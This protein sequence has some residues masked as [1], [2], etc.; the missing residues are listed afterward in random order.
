MELIILGTTMYSATTR[1]IL[2]KEGV[3]VLG[4]STYRDYI[5]E[6][7]YDGLPVYPFEELDFIFGVGEFMVINTIGYSNMNKIREKVYYDT[8]KKGYKLYTFISKSALVY[9][10]DIGEGSL[11]M[12]NAYIGPYVKL[13]A[14]CVVNP[15]T[16]LSHHITMGNFNFI[17]RGVIVGGDVEI[18]NNC[19]IG[20]HSTIKNK[21]RI[22]NFT[23][24][25]SGSNVIK[26]TEENCVYV[27]NPA[28][29]VE[30][31]G[32]LSTKI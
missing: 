18:C 13:G 25:G 10:D 29:K 12:P 15:G 3:R 22:S 23:I 4:Y 9:T 16:Q 31:K 28:R 5:Q 1:K 20:L 14:C 7:E 30:G 6:N 27:G 19:F 26:S 32:A 11:I 17:G 21:V 24:V 8:K 2:E